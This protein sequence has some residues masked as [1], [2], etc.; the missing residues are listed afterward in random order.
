MVLHF[1]VY[2]LGSVDSVGKGGLSLVSI[3][4]D[5]RADALAVGE[6]DIGVVSL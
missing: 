4:D 2:S 3:L 1:V 5:S 6:S